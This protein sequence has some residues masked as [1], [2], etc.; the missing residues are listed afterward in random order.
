[1]SSKILF[2][3]ELFL[4]LLAPIASQSA[5]GAAPQINEIHMLDAR[6]GWAWT[7]GL[8][9]H[10]H[11]LRTMDGAQTW[12]DVT[13]VKCPY[14]EEGSCFRDAKT[15]WVPVWNHTNASGGLLHTTDGGKSWTLLN[16]TN[17]PVYTEK[18]YCRFLSAAY[19]IAQT[20]DGGAGS[21]YYNYFETRD[22]GKSWKPIPLHPRNPDLN[23]GESPFTFHLS[24]ICEDR[25]AFNPPGT[26]VIAYGDMGDEKP[27]QAVRLSVSNDSGKNWRDLKL[28]L[29][30]TFQEALSTP[31]E[32]VFFDT[33]NAI[34][35][36]HLF[37]ENGDKHAYDALAFFTTK[38][39]GQSWQL[40]SGTLRLDSASC[41]ED[42]INAFA[43]DNIF[44]LAGNKFYVSH[45]GAR[46][47]RT[48][49]PNIA[50][51][52]GAKR[53]VLQLDFV[54]QQRGWMIISEDIDA[55]PDGDYILYKTADGG[56]TWAEVPICLTN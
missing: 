14:I 38:D 43:K 7:S 23:P 20:A 37:K 11:L 17:T 25:M 10:Q 51:G 46:S 27:K 22:G 19:G 34:L 39:G 49:T 33:N 52:K 5:P 16:G 24:N 6:H 9:E 31:D 21:S 29:P 45:D 12:T 26:L 53:E 40:T 13:P 15:A 18:S 36:S 47:W 44:V 56:E 2:L 42:K 1:M 3:A 32:P 50:F 4:A 55:H 28:P 8:A 54:D 30:A 41:P 48:V 35:D